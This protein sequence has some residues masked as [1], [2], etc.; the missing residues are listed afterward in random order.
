MP[1]GDVEEL[2][3]LVGSSLL[4]GGGRRLRTGGGWSRGACGRRRRSL[5]RRRARGQSRRRCGGR[6]RGRRRRGRRGWCRR[7]RGWRQRHG[8]GRSNERLGLRARGDRCVEG[9]RQGADGKGRGAYPRPGVRVAAR[10]GERDRGAPELGPDGRGVPHRVR[11]VVVDAEGENGRRR[12]A[13]RADVAV[14]KDR[15]SACRRRRERQGAGEQHGAE[16]RTW[17]RGA[18]PPQRSPPS[19]E[20]GVGH[21][22]SQCVGLSKGGII[23]LLGVG[24]NPGGRIGALGQ[25]AG[26]PMTQAAR[27]RPDPRSPADALRHGRSV[28]LTP[29]P[30]AATGDAARPSLR[31]RRVFSFRA[32]V[33]VEDRSSAAF[34]SSGWAMAAT[35]CASG[36]IW[37]WID[38]SSARAA[39]AA[40]PPDRSAPGRRGSA[41]PAP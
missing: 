4:S 34:T 10:E 19:R 27:L 9:H 22:V 2:G 28:G 16:D 33:L 35:W 12:A 5:R 3:A 23:A 11:R 14:G 32:R 30:H 25:R 40:D 29:N 36:M 20:L 18:R 6:S 8:D 1:L 41:A 24:G 13:A 15:V 39:A 31:F 38:G 7:G 37:T 26:R 17:P 21:G